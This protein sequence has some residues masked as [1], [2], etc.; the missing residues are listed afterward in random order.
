MALVFGVAVPLLQAGRVLLWGHWPP[1]REVP[2]D[3]DG[4]LAGAILVWGAVLV[5]RKAAAGPFLLS[6]GW[7]ICCGI[8]YRSFFEQLADPARHAGHELLVMPVKGALL[9]LAT[10]GLVGSVRSGFA[11]GR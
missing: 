11:V 3:L 8:L 5:T 10:V 7:G 1:M 4:Y 6:A 2:I 9:L